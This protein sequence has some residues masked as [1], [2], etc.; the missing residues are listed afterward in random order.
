MDWE[1]LKTFLAIA[2]EG[3]LSAGA[4]ALGV[5]QT[6]MGRRLEALHERIGAKLLQRTPAGFVLTSAGEAILPTV[7]RMEAEALAI[8]RTIGGEDIRLEGLVRITTVE[9]FGSEMIAPALAQLQERFPGIA[10]ELITDNRALSLARREADIA[11][12]LA[13][14]E[15]HRAVVQ[16][17]ADMA[18]G[19]YASTRYLAE[20]A[21][22]DWA[23]GAAG[24][25][26]ITLQDDLANVPEA[27]WL[28]A[29]ANA[30]TPGLLAD[31]RY[32]QLQACC[33]GLGLA[34]LP[35]YLADR[36]ANL[37]RLRPPTPPPARGI[38]LG[39]H[40]DL[41]RT[42]RIRAT[43]DVLV[44]AIRAGSKSLSPAD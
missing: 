17:V 16:R 18:F 42:P 30:A 39:V 44:A 38:W 41:R 36:H 14:F 7:E 22:P 35:R 34:C 25:R 3:N 4:R 13:T 8:E 21:M 5:S 26:L 33:A 20:R 32:V 27:L 15:Q 9:A 12:R 1:D 28:R 24:H 23:D 29:T 19:L 6:T 43:L 2:R 40:E 31:S 37:K 11:I 10:V